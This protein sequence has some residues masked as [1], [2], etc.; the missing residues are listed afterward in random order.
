M[1]PDVALI[2]RAKA[3]GLDPSGMQPDELE[4]KVEALEGADTAEE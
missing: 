2:E 1:T 3:L 4:R